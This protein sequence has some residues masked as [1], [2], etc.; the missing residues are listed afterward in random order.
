MDVMETRSKKQ[1]PE[2]FVKDVRRKAR[3]LFISEQ[4]ILSNFLQSLE[5]CQALGGKIPVVRSL[6]CCAESVS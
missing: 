6:S 3:R 1:T 4:K 2:N 5:F